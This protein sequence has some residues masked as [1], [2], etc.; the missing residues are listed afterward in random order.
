MDTINGCVRHYLFML[1]LD[2]SNGRCYTLD[3]KFLKIYVPNKIEDVNLNV[4]N[5]ITRISE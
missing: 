2:K 5:M 4:F 3:D 1:N